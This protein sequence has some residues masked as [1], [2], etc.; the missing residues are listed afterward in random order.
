MSVYQ[1][2]RRALLRGCAF[3]S[4]GLVAAACAPQVVKETVEVER[5]V[6]ET[7]IVEG[8]PQVVEKVVTVAPAPAEA[9]TIRYMCRSGAD[10]I[11]GHQK[12]LDEDFTGGKFPNIKVS[13]E[14]APDGWVEKLLAGMVAGSAVDIFE[15][16]GNIFYNWTERDLLLDLQPYVDK[17]MEPAEIATYNDFQ[18]QGLMMKGRRVGMPKYINLMTMSINKDMFDKYGVEYPP[19]DGN[20]TYDDYT[21]MMKQLTDAAASKGD[22]NVWA[23][24]LPMWNWDRFWGPIHSFGGKIVDS[25]YGKTC[26]M[27]RD[28]AQA[29]LKWAYEISFQTN[30]HAQPSQVEKKWP[31]DSFGPGLIMTCID[32]TYPVGREKTWGE[33]AK[34]RWDMRHVPKGPGGKRSVLGTTDAWSVTKQSKNPDQAWEVMHF[35]S[36]PIFQKKVIVGVDGIIP[37]LKPL[38]KDFISLLREQRPRLKDVRLETI[39]EILE[40][41]YAED[42]PWF[43]DQVKATDLIN[44]ALQKVYEVGDVGADYFIEIAKQVNDSQKDCQG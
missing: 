31:G 40:W 43:C 15:A 3:A 20:W 28:E 7:V 26:M 10:N 37:V 44:P 13:V 6:K 38:I 34:I 35:L 41:G 18:W 5:I 25:K 12:C 32:G 22:K 1:I 9:V 42:T 29:A 16:W 36:G 30:Y 19:E 27:D 11:P 39:D 4:V 23:G 14:P 8:T 33:Q 24:W 2:S 21:N 17:D